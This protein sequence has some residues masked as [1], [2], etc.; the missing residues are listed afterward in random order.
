M[1]VYICIYIYIYIHAYTH[2]HV[3][4][5]TYIFVYKIFATSTINIIFDVIEIMFQHVNVTAGFNV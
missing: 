5:N 3:C 4:I 2:I 1:G